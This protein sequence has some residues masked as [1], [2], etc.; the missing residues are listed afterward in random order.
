MSKLS[1]VFWVV[2]PCSVAVVYQ[3]FRGSCCL[4]L[5]PERF[6]GPCC[7]CFHPEDGGSKVL[8]NTDILPQHY[9]MSQPSRNLLEPSLL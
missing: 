5:H 3:R 4:H 2:T 9:T 8:R 6:G 1:P 7:L